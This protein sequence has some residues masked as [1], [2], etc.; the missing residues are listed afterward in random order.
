[1]LVPVLQL[2]SPVCI[3]FVSGAQIL[4]LLAGLLELKSENPGSKAG[5]ANQNRGVYKCCFSTPAFSSFKP[6]I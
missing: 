3:P 5:F 2:I 6:S 4:M 1:M